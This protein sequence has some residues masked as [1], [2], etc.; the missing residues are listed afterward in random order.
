MG[1]SPVLS[2]VF[3]GFQSFLS[4]DQNKSSSSITIYNYKYATKNQLIDM[5]AEL[6]PKSIRYIH[7]RKLQESGLKYVTILHQTSLQSKTE[8]NMITQQ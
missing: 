7:K 3:G 8:I 4:G 2:Y 6:L 5:H 1:F